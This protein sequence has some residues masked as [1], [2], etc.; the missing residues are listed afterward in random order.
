MYHH[1][2]LQVELARYVRLSVTLQLSGGDTVCLR[3]E[4]Y[5]CTTEVIP[6]TD[7]QAVT[8][9]E[10]QIHVKWNLPSVVTVLDPASTQTIV[11]YLRP[12]KYVTYYNLEN[13]AMTKNISSITREV[14]A[15]NTLLGT[16]YNISLICVMDDI[17]ISCRSTEITAYLPC[18]DGWINFQNQ[19]FQLMETA[20]SAG[21]AANSFM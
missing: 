17:N 6:L 5:G 7:I 21:Q 19:C 4:V 20:T 12:E 13:N 10:G 15:E 14:L 9:P 16:T 8:T 11:S 2:G 1:T 18:E 3:V